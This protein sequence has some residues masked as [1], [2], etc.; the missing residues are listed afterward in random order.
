MRVH[1]D[2]SRLFRSKSEN[3]DI[4]PIR[5]VCLVGSVNY[6]TIHGSAELYLPGGC[7]AGQVRDGTAADEYSAGAGR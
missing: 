3:T 7:Q 4:L 1:G 2:Q 6:R 5:R